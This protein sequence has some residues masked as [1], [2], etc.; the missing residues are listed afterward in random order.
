MNTRC[1]FEKVGSSGKFLPEGKSALRLSQSL[2]DCCVPASEAPWGEPSVFPFRASGMR[3]SP[4]ISSPASPQIIITGIC[5]KRKARNPEK[6]G[7]QTRNGAGKSETVRDAGS[8]PGCAASRQKANA[9]SVGVSMIK[10]CGKVVPC[11]LRSWSAFD[12]IK[13]RSAFTR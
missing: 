8:R 12:R 9:L 11:G 7:F 1:T 3:A 13:S 5:R 4:N 10:K 6:T 2:P